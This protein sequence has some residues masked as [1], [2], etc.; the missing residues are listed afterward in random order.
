MRKIRVAGIIPVLVAE[1]FCELAEGAHRMGYDV[2]A[3]SGY[4][5]EELAEDVVRRE[6]LRNV[7]VLID[8]AF[9]LEQ[10]TLDGLWKGSSNQR[11]VDV[12]SSLRE[13]EVKQ[14]EAAIAG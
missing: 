6:L 1:G 9:V 5:F 4:N 11:V 12:M 2:W 7:D 14:L 13:G 3:W 10:R 8:G